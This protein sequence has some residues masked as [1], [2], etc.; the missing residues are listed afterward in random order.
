MK[1]CVSSDIHRRRGLDGRTSL[2]IGREVDDTWTI[3]DMGISA[4]RKENHSSSSSGKKQNTSTPRGLQGRGRDYQGQ[5][6]TKASNQ[7]RHMTCY[8]CHQPGHMKQD[9]LRDRDPGVM[10]HHNPSHQ[11]DLH[12]RSLFP[13]HPNVGQGNRCQ[14]QGAAQAPII[15]QTSHMGQSMGRG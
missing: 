2:A 9:C 1:L 15:L 8:Y 11:W 4:K 3:Q 12:R 5:G 7:S 10:G 13:S 14:S 6:Q